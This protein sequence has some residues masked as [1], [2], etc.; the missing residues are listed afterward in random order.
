MKKFLIA[1]AALLIGSAALGQSGVFNATYPL[2]FYQT[3]FREING[4]QLNRVV[5]E[6]NALTGF[7]SFGLT[8]GLGY[9]T[10]KSV[11]GA[12]TQITSRSTGVTLNN[13]TGQITTDTSS[14]AAEATATFT[15]TDS[16]VALGDVPVLA[17]QSGTNGGGTIVY[18]STVAAGSFAISVQNNNASGGTAE[19]G[20]VIIN[21]AVIKGSVN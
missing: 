20:A 6:V 9:P 7:A 14:L 1:A 12:V 13:L 10:G 11:G 15:V 18:V 2:G 8:A 4:Q 21:F 3:G 5:A 19:T 17:I 16:K